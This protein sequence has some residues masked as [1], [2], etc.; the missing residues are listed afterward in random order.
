[1]HPPFGSQERWWWWGIASSPRRARFP[2]KLRRTITRW[3][4]KRL[5]PY[6]L[7]ATPD[8]STVCRR[9]AVGLHADRWPVVSLRRS[10]GP[11]FRLPGRPG[12]ATAGVRS[13]GSARP[14]AQLRKIRPTRDASSTC[15]KVAL[16]GRMS[17][18]RGPGHRCRDGALRVDGRSRTSPRT[19]MEPLDARVPQVKRGW[20]TSGQVW[21]ARCGAGGRLSP[22]HGL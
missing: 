7:P 17:G 4:K 2:G 15:L 13:Y 16:A 22:K 20:S 12:S 1:M 18:T 5:A 10:A 14:P 9:K 19:C 21:S 11:R 8:R 3:V 6:L